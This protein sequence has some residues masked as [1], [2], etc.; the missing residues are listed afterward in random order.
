MDKTM[1]K[2]AVF[3]IIIL[4]LLELLFW[5]LLHS[6]GHHVPKKTETSIYRDLGILSILLILLILWRKKSNR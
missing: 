3:I 1:S 5:F 6:S 4:M 2:V